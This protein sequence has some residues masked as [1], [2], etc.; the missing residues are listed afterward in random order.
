MSS[1]VDGHTRG[2]RVARGALFD[3][4][5]ALFLLL[6]SL[7]VLVSFA[8]R[9]GPAG[10]AA[11]TVLLVAHSGCLVWRRRAPMTVWAANLGTGVGVVALRFPLVTLGVAVL[12]ALYTVSLLCDRQRSLIALATTTAAMAA[13]VAF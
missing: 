6:V 2:R 13:G 9:R 10:V 7:S 11:A 4:A 3:A 12:V 8:D 5:V 1:A